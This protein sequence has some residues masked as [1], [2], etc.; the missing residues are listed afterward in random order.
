[1]RV[2]KKADYLYVARVAGKDNKIKIVE[3]EWFGVGCLDLCQEVSGE[4]TLCTEKK[5]KQLAKKIRKYC[6]EQTVVVANERLAREW[7]L[8][9]RLFHLRKWELKNN[10]LDI[11]R[12]FQ[13]RTEH[14]TI[15]EK[16][17]EYANSSNTRSR[18]LMVLESN[19]WSHKEVVE[20]LWVIKNCYEEIYIVLEN[21]KVDE[22]KLLD[23]FCEEC[24]ILIHSVSAE[25]AK[26]ISVDAVLFLIKE[27][28]TYYQCYS[29]EI[30]YVV[31]EWEETVARKRKNFHT[32]VNSNQRCEHK[33]LYA[34]LVYECEHT[35]L[36]YYKAL[37][38]RMNPMGPIREQEKRISIVAIYGIE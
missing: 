37:M 11:F 17:E 32:M 21:S 8:P 15:V 19:E 34:G 26:T 20:L 3:E 35:Q 38:F 9:N 25:F 7:E 23:F 24:G 12:Y 29:F 30:G 2:I 14:G 13:M 16:K 6:S 27:W 22:Q 33:E 31:A 36:P 1:M 10:A 28:S 18:F 4:T 5:D